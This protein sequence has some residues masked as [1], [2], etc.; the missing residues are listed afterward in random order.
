MLTGMGEQVDVLRMAS[1]SNWRGDS[2]DGQ[3]YE[4]HHSIYDVLVELDEAR[5]RTDRNHREDFEITGFLSMAVGEDIQAGDRLQLPASAG[6]FEGQLVAVEGKPFNWK[7][8]SWEPG[9]RVRFR[10]VGSNGR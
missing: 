9:K 6:M 4:F 3:G 5:Q 1:G 10:G 8:G 2:E 7:L